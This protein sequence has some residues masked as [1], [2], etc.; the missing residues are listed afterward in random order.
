MSATLHTK[1]AGDALHLVIEYAR[2]Q[3]QIDGARKRIGDALHGCPGVSGHRH[4]VES[5]DVDGEPY[6]AP[7]KRAMK[8]EPH[9]AG[10]YRP[11]V[12]QY[13]HRVYSEPSEAE[14]PHCWAA[15]QVVQERK[16]ARRALGSVKGRMRKLGRA[17][18]ASTKEQP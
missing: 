15:H 14:C 11:D 7:T 3:D 12:D 1:S 4:E 10:W 13:D 6:E 17:A 9:L 18:I 16:R 5:G 8:D 2:L